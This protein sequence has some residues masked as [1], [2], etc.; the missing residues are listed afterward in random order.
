MA[1]VLLTSTRSRSRPTKLVIGAGR[2]CLPVAGW[3][4]AG[5]PAGRPAGR[6]ISAGGYVLAQAPGRLAGLR[7][8]LPGEDFPEPF[9]LREGFSL[10][11]GECVETHQ[12]RRAPL[13]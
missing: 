5:E 8:Q 3:L 13:R 7:I 9:V 10:P 1:S 6:W 4:P 11:A 12:A 2:L